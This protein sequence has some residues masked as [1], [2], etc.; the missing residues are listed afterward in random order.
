M[1]SPFSSFESNM[2]IVFHLSPICISQTTSICPFYPSHTKIVFVFVF[3]FLLKA[4]CICQTLSSKL[5]TLHFTPSPKQLLWSILNKHTV[6]ILNLTAPMRALSTQKFP[7][8][9]DIYVCTTLYS[10]WTIGHF[11]SLCRR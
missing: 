11:P 6:K 2:Q 8:L 10:P 4:T 9:R 7:Q 5:C 3:E 1:F